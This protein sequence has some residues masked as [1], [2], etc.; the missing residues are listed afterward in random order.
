MAYLEAPE[1]RRARFTRPI[2]ETAEI[3][4]IVAGNGEDAMEGLLRSIDTANGS[5][6]RQALWGETR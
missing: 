1:P 3:S 2:L 4:W 5:A 6:L